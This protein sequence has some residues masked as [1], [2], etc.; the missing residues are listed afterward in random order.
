M[1][2]HILVS[3]WKTSL[4][5]ETTNFTEIECWVV[6]RSN[7][8][9]IQ[10]LGSSISAQPKFSKTKMRHLNETRCTFMFYIRECGAKVARGKRW[11]IGILLSSM[12]G[13]LIMSWRKNGVMHLKRQ[14]RD[15]HA[16]IYFVDQENQI[17]LLW[18]KGTLKYF[19]KIVF[20]SSRKISA[21]C[22]LAGN[23]KHQNSF[24]NR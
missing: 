3:F 9:W 7:H 2:T 16:R 14:A 12:T 11:N 13:I 22:R 24:E 19:E 5:R 1:F 17:F 23:L 20:L 4:W 15:Y 6:S 10:V 21:F 8:R 18:L